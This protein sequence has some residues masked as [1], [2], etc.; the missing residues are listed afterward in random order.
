MVSSNICFENIS[1][2]LE[3]KMAENNARILA[4]ADETCLTEGE[5]VYHVV[6]SQFIFNHINQCILTC[7]YDG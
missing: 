7:F 2:I 3:D 4:K 5:Q 1:G 6:L